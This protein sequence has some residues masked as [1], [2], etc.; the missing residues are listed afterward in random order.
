MIHA[1]YYKIT[2]RKT[3]D[4]YVGSTGYKTPTP[5][6]TRHLKMLNAGTHNKKFQKAWDEAQIDDWD[7]AVIHVEQFKTR[8]MRWQTEFDLQNEHKANLAIQDP[9]IFG[10]TLKEHQKKRAKEMLQ[11]HV[12]YRKI[13]EETGI[14]LGAISYLANN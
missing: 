3:G 11:H 1:L 14:S 6:W 9:R 12:S 5:A 2:N 13:K 4:C 8:D 7:F 10:R